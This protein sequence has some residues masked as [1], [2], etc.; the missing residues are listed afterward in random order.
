M[1]RLTYIVVLV[2][3]TVLAGCEP[4]EEPVPGIKEVDLF[5]LE[6]LIGK[7]MA[8]VREYLSDV[9][10]ITDATTYSWNSEGDVDTS[11][12]IVYSAGK[13]SWSSLSY[14]VAI[15]SQIG[16]ESNQVECGS[17]NVNRV[18]ESF[19]SSPDFTPLWENIVRPYAKRVM[20]DDS[21]ELYCMYY[22]NVIDLETEEEDELEDEFTLPLVADS[23]LLKADLL[24]QDFSHHFID[25]NK[26]ILS[27]TCMMLIIRTN[28]GRNIGLTFDYS[29]E[30]KH[31][32]LAIM[33]L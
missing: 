2:L 6:N 23:I 19:E 8:E 31:H 12:Q 27:A 28:N 1:K 21:V 33:L 10:L 17:I 22:L 3:F 5:A 7:S 32:E 14:N 30:D 18:G 4:Y 13:P 9:Q 24:L 20:L 25:P 26:E 29:P 11:V 15:R 16:W